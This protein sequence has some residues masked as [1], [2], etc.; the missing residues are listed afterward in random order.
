[1][2]YTMAVNIFF[3]K[4]L[5][6]SV[7]IEWVKNSKRCQNILKSRNYSFKEEA[8]KQH[9]LSYRISYT[10][11]IIF[12]PLEDCCEVFVWMGEFEWL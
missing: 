6:P 8:I 2:L 9:E 11:Y 3:V 5:R 4:I 10:P 7:S 12:M 1:M